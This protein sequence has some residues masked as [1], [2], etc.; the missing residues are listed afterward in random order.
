MFDDF[1][2]WGI[3]TCRAEPVQFQAFRVIPRDKENEPF[4]RKADEKQRRKDF[5]V[6]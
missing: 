5:C 1:G 4:A 6:S 3:A 2:F